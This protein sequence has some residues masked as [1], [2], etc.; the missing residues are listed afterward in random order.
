MKLPLEDREKAAQF[1][2][3]NSYE[4][5]LLEL[6]KRAYLEDYPVGYDVEEINKRVAQK[7]SYDIFYRRLIKGAH[8]FVHEYIVTAK[9]AVSL[10]ETQFL[11]L[12]FHP[13]AIT[14]VQP[15]LNKNESTRVFIVTSAQA[16]TEN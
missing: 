14:V 16:E 15:K 12:N 6:I 9:K 2:K 1:E 5:N 8:F 4:K 10:E 3:K 7:G 11:D 13:L